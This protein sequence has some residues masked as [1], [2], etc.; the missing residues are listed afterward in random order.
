[1]S[2]DRPEGDQHDCGLDVRSLGG[3]AEGLERFGQPS[4]R[5]WTAGRRR[6]RRPDKRDLVNVGELGDPGERLATRGQP[7]QAGRPGGVGFGGHPPS[8]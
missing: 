5:Q 3:V 4:Q 1:M 7:E 6:T 2:D 8:G